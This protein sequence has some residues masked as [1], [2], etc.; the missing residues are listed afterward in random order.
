MENALKEDKS[1]MV[2]REED[3]T[4]GANTSLDE[5]TNMVNTWD[6]ATD[7][8]R[9][10]SAK[11][12]RY[13][14]GKQWT[15][16]E[17]NEL[18]K[19]NSPAL[20]FNHIR[21]KVNTLR[22][23]EISD[24]R[25]P[26]AEPRTAAHDD[27]AQAV[28]DALRY[29]VD[30]EAVSFDRNKS[31]VTHD[32]ITAG[33]G[34][35]ILGIDV[36]TQGAEKL[37]EITFRAIA[38]DRFFFDPHS[39]E[40]DFSDADYL[41]LVMWRSHQDV[42]AS[43]EGADKII[44]VAANSSEDTLGQQSS[45]TL[46]DKPREKWFDAERK[47]IKVAEIYWREKTPGGWQWFGA[48]M[49]KAGF[50]RE[51]YKLPFVDDRGRSFCPLVAVSLYV[52]DDNGRQGVVH[53]LLSPQDEVNKRRSKALYASLTQKVVAEDGVVE[54]PAQ[55]KIELAKPDAFLRVREGSLSENSIMF[56]DSQQLTASQMQMYHDAKA[57]ID[58]IASTAGP[59]GAGD[60]ASA[61][62]FLARQALAQKELGTLKDNLRQWELSV[63]RKLYFL[64]RQYWTE[65]KW[66]RV[67]DNEGSKGYKFVAINKRMSR[68]ERYQEI[69][70]KTQ[71]ERG[72]LQAVLG[73]DFEAAQ[74]IATQLAKQLAQQTGQTP[75]PEI[76]NKLM[77]RSPQMQQDY[78]ANNIAQADVDIIIDTGSDVS[79]VEHEEF[80]DLVQLKSRGV[81]IPLQLIIEAS[82]LRSKQKL[83]AMLNKQPSPEEQ[84][85]AQAQQQLQ[86]QT[87]QSQIAVLTAE[88][89]KSQ[90]EAAKVAAEMQTEQAKMREI[91][92]KAE[93]H[94]AQ[95]AE[96]NAEA[97]REL[98]HAQ[99]LR[100]EAGAIA[101]QP[102]LE[103]IL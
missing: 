5:L 31:K 72:A 59:E 65:E 24:R 45:D 80:Q 18:K 81:D 70:E 55:A 75:G 97:E 33:Y 40:E 102:S 14:N 78:I 100:A 7:K 37:A 76:V 77:L 68:L 96:R 3:A 53:D 39:S 38:W 22:G 74:Q 46:G 2:A 93:A 94:L 26:V 86:M 101:S 48:H 34:A 54:S 89:Q 19:R 66:L 50:L 71:D 1:A 8:D 73:K 23:D 56:P 17:L 41:G 61:R 10:L 60:E 99:K 9:E 36:V 90:A 32:V 103:T 63:Y 6:E 20:T 13:Y 69:L 27:D 98:A 91:T 52:D 4:H 88:A 21:K 12:R 42:R 35:A 43:Y 51:P 95:A 64:I 47:R 83:L 25:D 29:V 87:V 15:K 11:C 82:G 49:N 58:G 44:E 16:E 79:V 57:E 28:T 30:S 84:Q 92:A 85:A 62:L 67:R